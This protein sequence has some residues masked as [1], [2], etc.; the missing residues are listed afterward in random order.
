MTYDFMLFS[1]N[2]PAGDEIIEV[3]GIKV[4]GCSPGEISEI[5]K[6][7]PEIVVCRIKPVSSV[8]IFGSNPSAKTSYMKLDFEE[9]A[10]LKAKRDSEEKKNEPTVSKPRDFGPPPEQPPRRDR[11]V[12]YTD[13]YFQQS[14]DTSESVSRIKQSYAYEYED[15]MITA[16]SRNDAT[17]KDDNGMVN[18]SGPEYENVCRGASGRRNSL[19]TIK[20]SATEEIGLNYADLDFSSTADDEEH[21]HAKK[22][23]S[24]QRSNSLPVKSTKPEL[25]G[26]DLS[27]NQDGNLPNSTDPQNETQPEHGSQQ[28]SKMADKPSPS[29]NKCLEVKYPYIE[30]DF[31]KREE[32]GE[33]HTDETQGLL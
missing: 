13:V 12:T 27:H 24:R 3:N 21:L 10:K 6:G 31:S 25:D 7:S 32:D 11:N 26:S 22:N 20:S 28:N 1:P 9:T 15:D 5:I 23:L 2:K 8:V 4:S 17:S 30:L 33:M 18:A 29:E 16:A 14:Q 19:P